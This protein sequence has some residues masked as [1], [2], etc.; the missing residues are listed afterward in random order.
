MD[1]SIFDLSLPIALMFFGA[2]LLVLGASDKIK[3]IRIQSNVWKNVFSIIGIIVF[4][5]GFLFSVLLI[6]QMVFGISLSP[7]DFSKLGKNIKE[8]ITFLILILIII[9]VILISLIIYFNRGAKI[10]WFFS[11]DGEYEKQKAGLTVSNIGIIRK[12]IC[13][14]TLRKLTLIQSNGERREITLDTVNPKREYL[15][16]DYG[17]EEIMLDKMSS[18]FICV[19]QI[20]KSSQYQKEFA[21]IQF[22]Q[23]ENQYKQKIGS[24]EMEIEFYR[25]IRDTK[26]LL[27]TVS[28]TLIINWKDRGSG[29]G[30]G[31]ELLWSEEQ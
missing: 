25:I 24:F 15:L 6:Y 13:V 18:K 14:A 28:N 27:C 26:F 21:Y 23:G 16:W 5:V 7:I 10:S 8:N 2:I 22:G 17:Q 20:A 31:I 12:L 29:K 19:T 30:Y 1:F 4:F 9:E 3:A 11:I